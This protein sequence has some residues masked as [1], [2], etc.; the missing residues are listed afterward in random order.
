MFDNPLP[1]IERLPAS[2]LKE[3]RGTRGVTATVSDV[4][5]RMGWNLTVPTTQLAPRH[6]DAA[7]V[8][9]YAV[10]T[11]YLPARRRAGA[12]A[13]PPDAGDVAPPP[14]FDPGYRQAQPGDV[15][16]LAGHGVDGT[17]IFG[18]RVARAARQHGIGGVVADGAVRDLDEIRA[19]GLPTWSRGVTPITG[20][21]RLEQVAMNRPVAI[22]GVQVHPGDLVIADLSGVC[23]VPSAAAAEVAA[24]VLRAAA[25]ELRSEPRSPSRP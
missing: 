19:A 4:L 12:D 17:S 25:T 11:E 5:D 16:V 6:L 8:V 2:V 3:L 20:K 7:V 9:G 13:A 21:T 14:A 15:L 18:G 10:T 22:A 24:Q 1:A 23:F